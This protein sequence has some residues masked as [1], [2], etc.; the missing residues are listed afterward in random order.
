MTTQTEVQPADYDVNEP[1]LAPESSTEASLNPA[2]AAE[3]SVEIVLSSDNGGKLADNKPDTECTTKDEELCNYNSDSQG[4]VMTTQTEVKTV[5]FDPNEQN[6]V[7]ESST[8][9]LLKPAF[10]AESSDEPL[11]L[12]HDTENSVV[13][14]ALTSSAPV[15]TELYDGCKGESQLGYEFDIG[16]MQSKEET[17]DGTSVS[18]DK[19]CDGMVAP[20]ASSKSK[21]KPRRV[22]AQVVDSISGRLRQRRGRSNVEA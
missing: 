4:L 6:I 8:D 9:P 19:N 18:D 15:H 3:S 17:E 1:N 10:A 11:L 14:S 12:K 5:K 21:K 2:F 7:S 16:K 22:A 13:G 20:E